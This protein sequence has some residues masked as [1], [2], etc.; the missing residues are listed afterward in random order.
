[1]NIA[2]HTCTGTGG[3]GG[4]RL[5]PPVFCSEL[6][7]IRIWYRPKQG[8]TLN[9]LQEVGNTSQIDHSTGEKGQ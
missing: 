6:V 2:E 5:I 8:I 1:M 3:G 9:G 7:L 4:T